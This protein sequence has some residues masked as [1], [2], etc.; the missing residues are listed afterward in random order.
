[1][2]ELTPHGMF[3][4]VDHPKESIP[5]R[6]TFD[7]AAGGTLTFPMLLRDN[8]TFL[9]AWQTILSGHTPIMGVAGDNIYILIEREGADIEPRPFGQSLFVDQVRTVLIDAVPEM[10]E[11]DSYVAFEFRFAH[12]EEWSQAALD[13]LHYE[14]GQPYAGMPDPFNY[15]DDIPSGDSRYSN[16]AVFSIVH[17]L[18]HQIERDIVIRRSVSILVRP[19]I[20]SALADIAEVCGTLESLFSIVLNTPAPLADL[21]VFFLPTS[22]SDK[23]L[24]AEVK[25]ALGRGTQFHSERSFRP[26][27]AL[28]SFEEL[29]GAPQVATWIE[30]AVCY[31]RV[32]RTLADDFEIPAGQV[33]TKLLNVVRAAEGLFSIQNEFEG[34]TSGLVKQILV[35]FAVEAVGV[36]SGII[37]CIDCWSMLLTQ[38]RNDIAH[39]DALTV[40]DEDLVN[41]LADSLYI[42]LAVALLKSCGLNEA[43]ESSLREHRRVKSLASA[44]VDVCKCDAVID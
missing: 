41:A 18:H 2:E 40:P 22:A 31:A 19:R 23:P 38:L 11:R 34:P 5:G 24:V 8:E 6:L 14:S 35:C 36:L 7:P 4:P 10:I 17:R 21:R 33:E 9:S 39:G 1:M 37:P 27:N 15:R 32:I 30:V 44:F 42:A 16:T 28:A 13:A 12:V 25:T 43:G 20:N 3:F 26:W 29:G